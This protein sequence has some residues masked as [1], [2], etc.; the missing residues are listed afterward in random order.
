ME[1]NTT[2]A[3]SPMTAVVICRFTFHFLHFRK[4]RSFSDR[5]RRHSVMFRIDV[6]LHK[7]NFNSIVISRWMERNK[8]DTMT[9]TMIDA[10]WIFVYVFL[11][12]NL[13]FFMGVLHAKVKQCKRKNGRKN[14][15]ICRGMFCQFS[16]SV[17]KPFWSQNRIR[18]EFRAI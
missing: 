17:S 1:N 16:F 13:F 18:F 6:K 5:P 15:L 10:A 12:S 3:T 2:I 11:R 9:K 7:T 8:V 14:W 4:I